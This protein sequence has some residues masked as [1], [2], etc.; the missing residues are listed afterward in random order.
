MMIER[1]YEITHFNKNIKG[2]L[3]VGLSNENRQRVWFSRISDSQTSFQIYQ[4]YGL[5]KN[6]EA[7]MDSL[8]RK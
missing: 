5:D 6:V 8:T 1:G 2:Y 4:G 3:M 7:I